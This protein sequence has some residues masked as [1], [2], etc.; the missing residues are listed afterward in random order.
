MPCRCSA[1]RFLLPIDRILQYIS[2]WAAIFFLS[3]TYANHLRPHPSNKY[4]VFDSYI[5]KRTE[6]VHVPYMHAFMHLNFI[7]L[8]S[9]ECSSNIYALNPECWNWKCSS[10]FLMHVCILHFMSVL[11]ETRLSRY[12]LQICS[13]Y[14]CRILGRIILQVYIVHAI[15]LNRNELLLFY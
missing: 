15:E 2:R 10:I 14:M 5:R 8:P 7:G 6:Y 1:H 11:Y 3:L 12:V 13:F 4:S 9:G